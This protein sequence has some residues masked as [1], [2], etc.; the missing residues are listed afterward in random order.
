MK[1]IIFS[2]LLF[3]SL[4]QS[5]IEEGLPPSAKTL[6][7]TD[8]S[9]Y[10]LVQNDI[11]DICFFPEGKGKW[12]GYKIAPQD[13]IHLSDFLKICFVAEYLIIVKIVYDIE[14]DISKWTVGVVK[15]LNS[16]VSQCD[17]DKCRSTYMYEAIEILLQNKGV[18]AKEY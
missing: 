11:P 17:D 12:D 10:Y 8:I 5:K 13:W 18:I 14:L 9:P 3:A 4:S 16:F 7:Q 2:L 6:I 1:C 15:T